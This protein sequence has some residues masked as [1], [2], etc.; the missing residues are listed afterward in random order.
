MSEQVTTV[1][2]ALPQQAVQPFEGDLTLQGIG[3]GLP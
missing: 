2:N 3:T 1:R